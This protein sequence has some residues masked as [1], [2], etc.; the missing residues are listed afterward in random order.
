[1]LAPLENEHIV[2]L[3]DYGEDG[4]TPFLVME[5]VEGANLAEV[6]RDRVF[7]WAEVGGDRASR[8]DGALVR[9]RPGDRPP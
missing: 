5:L 8:R 9:A 2:R 1:M 4:E 3:Y 7:S 6:A